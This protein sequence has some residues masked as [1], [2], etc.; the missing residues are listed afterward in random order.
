M[1]TKTFFWNILISLITA[2]VTILVYTSIINEKEESINTGHAGSATIDSNTDTNSF[3]MVNMPV[4]SGE[5]YT[6]FTVAAEKSV[7]SVVHVTSKYN[8]E[9]NYYNNPILELFFG[10]G[11]SNQPV[12]SFGSGVIVSDDGYIVTN[13]HVVEKSNE[14]EVILNDKRSFTAEVI[15]TDPG[16]DL[17]LLKVKET[18][19]PFIQFGNSDDAKVGEWVLAVGNPFNLTSTVTAGIVSAKARNINL[20]RDQQFPLE[21]Y[22]QTDAAVNKGNSGGALVN[23]EG[24]LIGINSAILS[25]SGSYSGYSFAIPVN[26]VKKVIAD[27]IKYGEVQ[28]AVLGVNIADVNNEIVQRLNLDKIEGVYVGGV[29]ENG[30]AEESGMRKDDIVLSI[31][32]VAVNSVAELT[33]QMGKYRPGES[34]NIMIK[35]DNKRKE[36]AVILKNV[37]GNTKIVTVEESFAALGASFKKIE[38]N[39]LKRFGIENGIQISDLNDGV[40][41]ESGIK[42]DFIITKI[43]GQRINS[44][45]ELKNILKNNKTLIEIEGTYPGARYMYIYRVNFK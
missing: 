18:G 16:T 20:L 3:H 22:I 2:L 9:N 7:N 5:T 15:G 29:T 12:M 8:I 19:L 40:L 35:R 17:A 26:I 39:D 36:L 23:L 32:N 27:L 24:K 38:G 21:S 37:Q 25:P 42:K 44:V 13:Y 30:A 6:D 33:E 11:Y 31:N 34:V 41:K 45:D 4:L 10:D 43:Q 28:R 1:K 14:I